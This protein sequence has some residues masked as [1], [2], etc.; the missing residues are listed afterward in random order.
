MERLR[1]NAS[2][3]SSI[4]FK[5]F[6]VLSV[7]IIVLFSAERARAFALLGPPQPWMQVTNGVY[8]EADYG[9][10]M[11]IGN[12]YRWNVPVLTYG[13]DKSFVDYFGSNGVAAVEGA[14]QILNDLPPAS[15]I[16]LTNFPQHTTRVNYEAQ[17]QG[18]YDLK[19]MTLSL[20]LEQM[21]LAKP[22]LNLVV[23]KQWTPLFDQGNL[24]DNNPVYQTWPYPDY[25]VYRNFDPTT[26]LPSWYID[27]SFYD[28]FI[29][30]EGFAH[31]VSTFD[32]DPI[33]Q[34]YSAVTDNY[35]TLN[36]IYGNYY[37]GLTEDDVGGL[38][39]LLS[40]NNV[41]YENLL[42]DV[43]GVGK[44]HKHLVRGAQR[45]GV[46]KITHSSATGPENG[47][48]FNRRPSL[49]RPLYHKRKDGNTGSGKGD[50]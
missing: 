44:Y 27:G 4:C 18:L 46:D 21:G 19:S 11:D 38:R 9:G 23:I 6:L 35:M 10:P 25:L 28:A 45:P 7:C 5:S 30:D 3:S 1:T 13:F 40:T 47:A 8:S 48:I 36:S 37:N 2:N 34:L 20:L 24:F 14:F 26:L 41:N 31:F 22:L 12:G 42:P 16:V 29:I 33:G 17:S 32:P 15:L 49:Y 39:Y 43:R 50:Y